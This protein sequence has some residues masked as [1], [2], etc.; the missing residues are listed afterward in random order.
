ML[1]CRFLDHHPD[2]RWLSRSVRENEGIKSVT[3]SSPH[4]SPICLEQDLCSHCAD[5]RTH[6]NAKS[7]SVVKDLSRPAGD[8][9]RQTLDDYDAIFEKYSLFCNGR[10]ES[11]AWEF[12][13]GE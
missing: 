13:A 4:P 12:T 8:A 1:K 11:I 3:S 6:E 10:L 7:K 5:L 9:E 2:L